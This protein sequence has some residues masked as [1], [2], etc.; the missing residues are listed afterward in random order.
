MQAYA[1]DSE[2]RLPPVEWPA[3][4]LTVAVRIIPLHHGG[5]AIGVCVSFKDVTEAQQLGK[6]L[7]RLMEEQQTSQ[8][9]LQSA[10]EEQ[11]TTNEELQS[12]VEEL[13]TTNEELQSSN[14]EMET[15][16]EELQS[17]NEELQTVNEEL[18]RRSEEVDQANRFLGGILNGLTGGVTVLDRDMRVLIWSQ[19]AE[20]LWGVREDEARDRHFL[21]LDFGLPVGQL[22]DA[23]HGCL[24][25]AERQVTLDAVN[26]RGRAIRCH[27]TC[28]PLNG[29]SQPEGPLSS[30]KRSRSRG[31]GRRAPDE[32]RPSPRAPCDLKTG[33]RKI[34]PRRII[35]E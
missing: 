2:V 13:E 16:N 17:A 8:E 1:T 20:E 34:V 9:E 18:R 6:Q 27:V 35:R 22:V 32:K 5:A 24:R 4:S 28:T 25:G 11:E 14:E 3:G 21:N 30:C 12:T 31:S 15:I 10:Y 29:A 33:A 7:Q 19:Q 26:R 23:L